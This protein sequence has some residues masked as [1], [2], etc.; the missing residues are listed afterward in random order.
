MRGDRLDGPV[1]AGRVATFEDDKDLAIAGDDLA[2]Q[3]DQLDLE[4][5]QGRVIVDRPDLLLALLR[6][7]PSSPPAVCRSVNHI[8]R[9]PR[10]CGP[11]SACRVRVTEAVDR[12]PGK[13]Y[14]CKAFVADLAAKPETR[15][16]A[17]RVGR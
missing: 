6:H 16:A 2:L 12:V 13:S 10:Y 9:R 7:R 5:E 14:A 8:A 4:R 11:P 1:L 17:P 15:S 3:L